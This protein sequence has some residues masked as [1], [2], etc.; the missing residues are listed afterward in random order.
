MGLSQAGSIY[1]WHSPRVIVTVVLGF[2][3]LIA[4][5]FALYEPHLPLKEP[6]APVPPFK[7]MQ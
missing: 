1:P 4:F 2:F 6:L 3:S 5:S 7:I